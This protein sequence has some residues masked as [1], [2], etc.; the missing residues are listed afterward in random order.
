LHSSTA[1]PSTPQFSGQLRMYNKPFPLINRQASCKLLLSSIPTMRC[2]PTATTPHQS[3]P[4]VQD[5]ISPDYRQVS[6]RTLHSSSAPP[7]NTAVPSPHFTRRHRPRQSAP[8]V[9]YP[10]APDYRQVSRET[11]HSSTLT[12]HPSMSCSPV[13]TTPTRQLR[14]CISTTK[15]YELSLA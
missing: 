12:I 15:S 7:V 9:Q 10:I 2:S 5:P 4:N 1:S 11:L 3:A 13:A 8:N 14:K 6:R